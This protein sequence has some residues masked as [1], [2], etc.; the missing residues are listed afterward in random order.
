VRL[1]P[2]LHD[3]HRLAP[4]APAELFVVEGDSAAQA[5]CA[6]RNAELQAVLPIQ[7]KPVNAA[8][9]SAA[10]VRQ[11]PWLAALTQVLGNAPGTALPFS[12]L[13]FERVILLMDP[14]ADGIHTG[15]LLQIFFIETMRT[16]LEQGR[17]EIVHAPWAEIRRVGLPPLLSFHAEEFRNQCRTLR[18]Q[19]DA[20][21]ES[22]RHRG[23]GSITPTVLERVC[24]NPATRRS[25]VLAMGDAEAARE[26]FGA[27]FR[28]PSQRVIVDSD[29]F[30]HTR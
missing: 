28:P 5:V 29:T 9:A 8:R 23:L 6:V 19:A 17:V 14:D 13:R 2:S 20:N 7:G 30:T 25:R 1:P 11:S 26:V 15:A 22:I 21:Y 24:I 3:S 27:T 10:R 4:E 18:E 16:L 12:D